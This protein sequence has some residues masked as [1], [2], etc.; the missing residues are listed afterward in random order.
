MRY[1]CL[2]TH[3]IFSDGKST[4]EEHI[5]SAIKKG[6]ASIG[7][8]DHSYTFFDTSYCMKPEQYPDYRKTVL[9]MQ[10]KYADQIDVFL[11]LELDG[12]STAPEDMCRL[13]FFH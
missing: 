3:S 10:K 7:F 12:Y 13:E 8:T 6:F 5:L 4:V 11:G 2:H 1:T 9:E